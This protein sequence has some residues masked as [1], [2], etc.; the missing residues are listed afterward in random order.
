MFFTRVP[1]AATLLAV[2][3]LTAPSAHAQEA[4]PDFPGQVQTT[5]PSNEQFLGEIQD[6][7]P[8]SD[9]ASLADQTNLSVI[10]GQDLVS[11]LN[12]ALIT[13]PDDMSRSRIE[14]VLTHVQASVN[15]LQMAQAETGLDAAR[16]RLDQARGEAQEGLDELR[17][18]VLGMVST[19]AITGK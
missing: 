17:P 7:L 18:F 19:G 14:G 13:A 1:F 9:L 3:I 10:T 15:A 11:Q 6:T 16:G 8:T 5:L 2:A 12:S 4:S